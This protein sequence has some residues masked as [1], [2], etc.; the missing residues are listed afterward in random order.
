MDQSL[1]PASSLSTL[2]GVANTIAAQ[3][4]L[5]DYQTKKSDQTLRRQRADL[6][7]FGRF[8]AEAEHTPSGQVPDVPMLLARIE[9]TAAQHANLLY[10]DLAAW[11]GI[12]WGLVQ[13]FVHWQLQKAYAVG[14]IN[15]RLATIK[16][17]CHLARKYGSL[18]ASEY[19]MIKT[20]AGFDQT[21]ARNVNEKREQSRCGKKKA[22]PVSFSRA[23]VQLLKRRPDTRQGRRDALLM[24]L[25]LDLGLRCGE[26][27]DLN[28]T[29]VNLHTGM[30]TFYRHKVH[31]TQIHQMTPDT[32]QAAQKYL[33]DLPATQ[34]ALFIGVCS[35]A[36]IDE[37]SIN[38]RVEAL[39]KEVGIQGKNPLSP[40]DCRH[41]WTTSAFKGG[42]HLDSIQTA[43]GWNSPV[44]ALRYA[45][46]SKI[47]NEGIKLG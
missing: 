41:Y 12:T 34:E 40:H 45:E 37:R 11:R 38:S 42:S 20:V 2:G 26:I 1:E 22:D 13:S 14:S 8:L 47:A 19:A 30:I 7:L 5:E 18:E 27:S 43:G 9:T 39:G 16:A 29:D 24:C 32:L 28:V 44:M 3:N 35:K 25:L 4:I 46:A 21:E 17:Y 15:V 10:T 36:R 23:H 31:K 33:A 6:A